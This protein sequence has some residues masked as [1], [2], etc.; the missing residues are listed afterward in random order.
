MRND[1]VM[2]LMRYVEEIGIKPEIWTQ[3]PQGHFQQR[4]AVEQAFV[5]LGTSHQP[6]IGKQ[7][8]TKVMSYPGLVSYEGGSFHQK[9]QTPLVQM[10]MPSPLFVRVLEFF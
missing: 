1:N 6:R 4:R 5:R 3:A 7:R 9:T 10:A 2:R 8:Q